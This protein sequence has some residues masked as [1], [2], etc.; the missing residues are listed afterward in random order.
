MINIG[1]LIFGMYVDSRLQ[2]AVQS[3]ITTEK[4]T[5]MPRLK[6]KSFLKPTL[7]PFVIDIMLFGP[8]VAAVVKAY[9]KKLNH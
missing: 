7:L 1:N 3:T 6:G 2:N 8:G 5:H 9:T 4:P